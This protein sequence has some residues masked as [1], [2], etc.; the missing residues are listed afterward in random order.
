MVP[1]ATRIVG[2][3]VSFKI[4]FFSESMPRCGISGSYDDSAEF[5]RGTLY[6]LSSWCTS[7]HSRKHCRRVTCSPHTLQHLLLQIFLNGHF[8]WCELI[9][10]WTLE[11]PIF[12]IMSYAEHLFIW[13]MTFSMPSLEK[14]PVRTLAHFLLCV[15]I[16]IYIYNIYI[17]IE[18]ERERERERESCTSCLH[19][20]VVVLFANIFPIL[21]VVYFF[22]FRFHLLCQGCD[23]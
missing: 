8:D 23:S 22:C 1:S 15:Y 14:C 18:R 5:L 20:F 21:R 9:P 10:H 16:Y 19:E 4:L 2:V 17:Y 11:L 7:L 3:Q 12:R 13:W 6:C